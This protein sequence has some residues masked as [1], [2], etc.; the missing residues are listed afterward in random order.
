MIVNLFE[1]P[2]SPVRRIRVLIET[3]SVVSERNR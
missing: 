1:E 2:N 3:E